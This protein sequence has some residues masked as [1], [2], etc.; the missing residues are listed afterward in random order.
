MSRDTSDEVVRLT[1]TSNPAQAHI[2]EQTLN[3]EGIRATVVGDYLDAGVGD[4]PGVQPEVW[5]RR[6]DL[7]RALE[8]LKAGQPAGDQIEKEIAANI[9]LMQRAGVK[10][11]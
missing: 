3:A 8:V 10:L 4:I 5:V 2:L 7:A 6:E 1:T 9:N 11:N